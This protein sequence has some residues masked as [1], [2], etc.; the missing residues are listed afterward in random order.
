M[1]IATLLPLFLLWEIQRKYIPRK[2]RR[3][4][5]FPGS[6][7]RSILDGQA[8]QASLYSPPSAFVPDT[9]IYSLCKSCECISSYTRITELQHA[10]CSLTHATPLRPVSSPSKIRAEGSRQAACLPTYL[11][12]Y[13]LHHICRHIHTDARKYACCH[14]HP[15]MTQFR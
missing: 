1:K 10:S 7:G 2:A 6:A 13:R 4:M 11:S 12:T 9:S 5:V 14:H 8:Q 3:G 15:P